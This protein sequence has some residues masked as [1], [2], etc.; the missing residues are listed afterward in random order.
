[1]STTQLIIL[2]LT[3]L[4]AL[5]IYTETAKQ[6]DAARTTRRDA[7][8]DSRLLGRDVVAHT[9]DGQSVRGIV[10]AEYSDEL[11]LRAATYLA[12]TGRTPADGLVHLPKPLSSLQEITL[13]EQVPSADPADAP[14]GAVA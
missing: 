4:A 5:V 12:A 13:V 9:R 7:G 3:A 10:A 11:V 2:C 8:Q 14:G 6:R 1:M